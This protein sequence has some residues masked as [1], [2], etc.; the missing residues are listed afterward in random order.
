MDKAELRKSVLEHIKQKK[1]IKIEE[2][3]KS[4]EIE[5]KTLVEILLEL[6]DKKEI[7]IIEPIPKNKSFLKYF[8]DFNYS[9]WY[10]FVNL[11]SLIVVIMNIIPNSIIP[12]IFK[13]FISILFL[14]F[15]PG[16]TLVQFLFP[17]REVS[18]TERFALSIGISIALVPVFGLISY[19][20]FRV[21]LVEATLL[22]T[23]FTIF[24][25][26]LALYRKYKIGKEWAQ[27]LH[28]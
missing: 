14:V 11:F 26:S 23:L 21:E 18:L 22:I 12:Y 6:E 8:L 13:S 2:L 19:Y 20:A 1:V 7:A 15:F 24:M 5:E 10:H 17:K 28:L 3:M 9:Y 16:F 27:I 25:N 4:L